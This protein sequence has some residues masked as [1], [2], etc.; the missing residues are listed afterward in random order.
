MASLCIAL[1][2]I[3][4]VCLYAM[5]YIGV[6]KR[7]T[8]EIAQVTALVQAKLEAKVAK[9]TALLTAAVILTLILGGVLTVLGDIFPVFR[10]N[11][12]FRVAETLLQLNSL[13]N[14]LIYCYRDRRFR[15]AI[16]ELLRIKKPR[17]T[18][19]TSD[20]P[21]R[22]RKGKDREGSEEKVQSNTNSQS[23]G[24]QTRLARFNIVR[25]SPGLKCCR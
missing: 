8:N 1:S 13:M 23:V 11:S 2:F 25:F 20:H 15:K 10:E 21:A 22:F 24:K 18:K 3:T 4:F 6:R 9:T 7:R 17:A 16:L 19:P 5:V 14:P 12:T